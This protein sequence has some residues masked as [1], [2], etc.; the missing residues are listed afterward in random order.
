MFDG[1]PSS[2]EHFHQ[3]ITPRTTTSTTL[4]LPHHHH[5]H[6]HHHLS[7]SS[8]S[9]SSSFS[10][11]LHHHASLTPINTNTFL[12]FDPYNPH[13]HQQQQQP[14][15][16]FSSVLNN[17]NLF[18]TSATDERLQTQ[19]LPNDLIDSSWSNDEVVALL[20][21]RSTMDTTWFPQLTYWDHVSR[22]L[23][24]LGFKK[25]GDKCKE[26]FEDETRYFNNYAKNNSYRFLNELEEFYQGD[27]HNENP[28]VDNQ[29]HVVTE[30]TQEFE[31]PMNAGGGDIEEVEEE[32]EEEEEEDEE[33]SRDG[34]SVKEQCEED[35]ESE[36]KMKMKRKR[37]RRCRFEMLKG[38]C[39]SIVNNMMAQQ[40]EIHNKLIEDMLRRDEEKLQREEAWKKQETERMNK[41]LQIMAQEQAIAGD[42]QASIIEFLKKYAA[43]NPNNNEPTPS[44]SKLIIPS[45]HQVQNSSGF[46]S[47][48]PLSAENPSSMSDTLLQQVHSSSTHSSP[49]SHNNTTSSSSLNRHDNYHSNLLVKPLVTDQKEN[50]VGRRW[51]RD[52]VLALINLRCES[53]KMNNNAEERESGNNNKIPLWERISQGMSDLGYKRS[54]K[55]CKEKWENINKYFRKTK[56]VNKKRSIDSRTCPYFHQLKS[57][58]DEG[59]LVHQ[60]ETTTPEN[61]SGQLLPPS[62]HVGSGGGFSDDHEKTLIQEPPLNFG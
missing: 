6:H 13:H 45:S 8:S 56:D 59:K 47:I 15:A 17:N 34:K 24:E 18:H 51:P 57:L 23:G 39:E 62:D 49:A 50:N 52:E 5:H 54:A 60:P 28:M 3:F 29:D 38:F 55:R 48:P 42:R 11:L 43:T 16:T 2:S 21:I 10:P 35:N 4:P 36:K 14:N 58:Y 32:E 41:E 7:P 30:K 1:L 40:E 53:I 12:P 19:V 27:N 26:K 9:S 33:S 61:H 37:K 44:S 31:H 20:R 25:S 22:K 46:C